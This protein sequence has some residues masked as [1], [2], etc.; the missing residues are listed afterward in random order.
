[1]CSV[2]KHSFRIWNTVTNCRNR[3]YTVNSLVIPIKSDWKH[4]TYHFHVAER[5]KH[6][7]TL[8]VFCAHDVSS[9]W[10][11]YSYSWHATH[12]HCALGHVSPKSLLRYGI[13][14][15]S[16]HLKKPQWAASKLHSG[17]QRIVG[18]GPRRVAFSHQKGSGQKGLSEWR[19]TS[20]ERS[21]KEERE[22]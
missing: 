7:C 21:A 15:C 22:S 5:N 16:F 4:A 2:L 20:G 18:A 19:L 10:V 13:N 9:H 6:C 12:T 17:P 14:I 1:M 8:A 11:L 3:F